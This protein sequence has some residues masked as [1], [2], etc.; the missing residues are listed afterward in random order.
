[1]SEKLCLIDKNVFEP[2]D[3]AIREFAKRHNLYL[4]VEARGWDIRYLNP[5][6]GYNPKANI[7]VS[8]PDENGSVEVTAWDHDRYLS[9]SIE[10]NVNTIGEALEKAWHIFQTAKKKTFF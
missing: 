9:E 7:S 4:L 2:F 6:Y 5:G 3:P 1:M 10:A 8:S